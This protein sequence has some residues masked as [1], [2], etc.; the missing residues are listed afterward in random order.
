MDEPASAHPGEPTAC[1]GG[2]RCVTVVCCYAPTIIYIFGIDKLDT[3]Y[4]WNLLSQILYYFGLVFMI[5]ISCWLDLSSLYL[6]LLLQYWLKILALI[7][8]RK[9]VDFRQ[10][11]FAAQFFFLNGKV[12]HYWHYKSNNTLKFYLIYI[13][14][15]LTNT[16]KKMS[17]LLF[18]HF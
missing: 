14:E 3:T 12:L 9:L 18:H 13:I 8:F 11:Q 10:N 15:T 1:G 5:I 6:C 4:S 16:W 7:S 17:C 2:S